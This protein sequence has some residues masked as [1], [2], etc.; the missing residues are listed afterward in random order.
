[1]LL[2]HTGRKRHGR[3]C[4]DTPF[5]TTKILTLTLEVCALKPNPR[6]SDAFEIAH[7]CEYYRV[8]KP[9]KVT[10]ADDFVLNSLLSVFLD[11][12]HEIPSDFDPSS[13]S[14]NEVEAH[15]NRMYL[16]ECVLTSR[17]RG[18]HRGIFRCHRKRRSI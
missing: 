18:R 1:M 10:M 11:D 6:A 2:Y 9:T 14:Q 16:A 7:P 13:L 8:N 12:Y 4:E 15:V 17:N 3:C 5:I